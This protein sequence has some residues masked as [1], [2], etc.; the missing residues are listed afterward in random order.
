[1]EHIASIGAIFGNGD[2]PPLQNTY[3]LHISI[4]DKHKI[5]NGTNNVKVCGVWD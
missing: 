4:T 2:T 3:P 1:M 5:E